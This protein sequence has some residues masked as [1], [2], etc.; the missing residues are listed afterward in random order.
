MEPEGLTVSSRLS[1]EQVPWSQRAIETHI[2]EN[3]RGWYIAYALWRYRKTRVSGPAGPAMRLYR[4][5]KLRV[6]LRPVNLSSLAFLPLRRVGQYRSAARLV[7]ALLEYDAVC[8]GICN[9]GDEIVAPRLPGAFVA[10][11]VQRDCGIIEEHAR[12]VRPQIGIR[13]RAALRQSDTPSWALEADGHSPVP[14]SASIDNVLI[15][16]GEGAETCC[17]LKPKA[18]H[19]QLASAVCEGHQVRANAA[20]AIYAD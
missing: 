17:D 14:D 16:S 20:D 1:I 7:D 6:D 12:I 11:H 15:V 5:G 19:F 3:V 2:A 10:G 18:L 9:R 8:E 13:N 4:Q